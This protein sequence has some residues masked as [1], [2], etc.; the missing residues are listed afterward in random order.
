MMKTWT[1]TLQIREY[2]RSGYIYFVIFT[3]MMPLYAINLGVARLFVDSPFSIFSDLE[4][5]MIYVCFNLN[6]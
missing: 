1:S 5:V 2:E 6:E 4:F 3:F